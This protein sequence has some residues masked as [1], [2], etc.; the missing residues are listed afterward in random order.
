MSDNDY[1]R[2][3]ISRK[4]AAQRNRTRMEH[5]LAALRITIVL[6]LF[7]ALSLLIWAVRM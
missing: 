7:A 6:F 5:R 4:K 2:R 3:E 1:I